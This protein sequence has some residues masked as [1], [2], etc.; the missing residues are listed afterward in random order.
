MGKEGIII[1][2]RAMYIAADRSHSGRNVAAL[3][4]G[5]FDKKAWENIISRRIDHSNLPLY[6]IYAFTGETHFIL[7]DDQ[8]RMAKRRPRLRRRSIASASN[9]LANAA[10]VEIL[11]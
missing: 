1:G 9:E 11:S 3:N 4:H 6:K 5:T 10:R 7:P 2:Q 8:R